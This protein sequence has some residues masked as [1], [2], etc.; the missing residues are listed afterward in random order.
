M[1][2]KSQWPVNRL[3]VIDIRPVSMVHQPHNFG[4]VNINAFPA[5]N[6]RK[7]LN[8]RYF[9]VCLKHNTVEQSSQ[10]TVLCNI[11]NNRPPLALSQLS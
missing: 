11:V 5:G 8:I 2:R 6:S 1:K 7:G 9:L 3:P 4:F 10:R